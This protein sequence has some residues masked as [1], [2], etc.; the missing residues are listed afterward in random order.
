ML[1]EDESMHGGDRDR[2]EFR[3]QVERRIRCTRRA[4]MRYVLSAWELG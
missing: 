3:R 2:F 4:W 1:L